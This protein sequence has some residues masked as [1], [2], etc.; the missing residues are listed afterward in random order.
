MNNLND[1]QEWNI[2]P[3]QRG[4]GGGSDGNKWNYALLVPM[5]GLAAFRWIWSRESQREVLEVKEKYDKSMQVICDNMELKYK[6]TLRENRRET[7]HL[8][9][10][11]EKEKNRVQGY[12]QAI[13]SQSQQLMEERRRLSQ[14]REALTR[15]KSRLLQ[16]GGAG[17]LLHTALERESESEWHRGAIAALREVEEGLVER[18]GAFCSILVPR[19]KRLEMEKDLL[20]RAGRE[21]A[22]AQLDM[23]AGLKDIFKNDRHC[24]QYLNTDKRKNGS[25]MWIYL[26]YWQLQV[27]LQ[28]HRRAEATLLETQSSNL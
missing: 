12:R 28:K 24:A 23:E 2:R 20:V 1:P 19:E 22:L 11:L 5:I 7:V 17:A 6:D 16:A 8:E 9:L 21:R 14:E 10:E 27:T 18:Q 15:E 4:G 25:L 3:E 13:A 26:R